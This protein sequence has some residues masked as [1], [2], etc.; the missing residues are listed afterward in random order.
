MSDWIKIV[1]FVTLYILGL[2]LLGQVEQADFGPIMLGFT[3]SFA[4]YFYFVYKQSYQVPKLL[5]I[6]F[7]LGVV[8][9]CYFI[10]CFPGLSDDIYRFYWDGMLIHDGLNPYTY[11]PEDLITNNQLPETL[12]S[13]VYDKLNSKS[14][15]SIY[16]PFAQLIYYLASFFTSIETFSIALKSILFLSEIWAVS[17]MFRLLNQLNLPLSNVFVYFLNPLV[18]VEGIGNLHFEVL[19]VPFIVMF[20]LNLYKREIGKATFHYVAAIAIKFTPLLIGPLILFFLREKKYIYRFLGLGVLFFMLAFLPVLSGIQILNLGDSV[21]LYFRKFEFNASL[22]YLLREIGYSW[23]GYNQIHFIGPFLAVCTVTTIVYL[24]RKIEKS[25]LISFAELSII[26]YLIYLCAATTV[27]PWYLI[28]ILVFCIVQKSKAVLLWTYLITLS[29]YTY[30][31]PDWAESLEFSLIQYVPIY[32]LIF[33]EI[34]NI[35]IIDRL[36]EG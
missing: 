12:N 35:F 3:I 31:T 13:G 32:V 9:R 6:L 18:I 1:F 10:F 34:R 27:H 33:L 17:K 28:P 29:Y 15:Y 11:L 8:M 16:P 5:S 21:D 4:A 20:L 2:F 14:Y 26:S 24:S 25:N 23:Y 30:S 7:G 22:Y 36:V 19:M